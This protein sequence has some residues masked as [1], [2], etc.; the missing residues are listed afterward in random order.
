MGVFV[1]RQQELLRLGAALGGAARLLLVVGD[2]WV[3]KTRLVAEGLRPAV[4]SGLIA[5]TGGCLPLAESCRCCRSWTRWA[6]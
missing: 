2:A 1:G 5:V 3:G 4:T 6:T